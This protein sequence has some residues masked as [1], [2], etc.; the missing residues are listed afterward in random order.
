[1]QLEWYIIQGCIDLSVR[2]TSKHMLVTHTH[3]LGES[4]RCS[5]ESPGEEKKTDHVSSRLWQTTPPPTTQR[6]RK[7]RAPAQPPYYHMEVIICVCSGGRRRSIGWSQRLVS[8]ALFRGQTKIPR[9]YG[10][11]RAASV[12]WRVF[13]GQALS[14]PLTPL[15]L[16]AQPSFEFLSGLKK[17]WV[18]HHGR[19]L[20]CWQQ[21]ARSR[22]R[23]LARSTSSQRLTVFVKELAPMTAAAHPPPPA[24]VKQ[25]GWM[26]GQYRQGK[27]HF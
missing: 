6:N 2:Q 13:Y 18:C 5:Q 11:R 3:M 4:R 8:G 10:K 24:T 20:V 1:M 7:E 17:P 14:G 9:D 15:S 12:W 16:W 21:N 27:G 26:L 23:F 22:Q 19:C 25:L